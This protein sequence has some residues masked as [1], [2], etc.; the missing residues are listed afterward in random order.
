MTKADII[1]AAAAAAII[2]LAIMSATRD[3]GENSL[4]AVSGKIT[5]SI[6]SNPEIAAVFGLTDEKAEFA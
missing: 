5:E 3:S 4:T 6:K 2:I 1:K